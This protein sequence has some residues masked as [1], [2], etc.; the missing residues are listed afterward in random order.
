VQKV[1]SDL[2][3]EKFQFEKCLTN[4]GNYFIDKN[5]VLVDVRDNDLAK[6]LRTML[7]TEFCRFIQSDH[8]KCE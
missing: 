2:K 8:V 4:A 7:M 6:D 1:R 5:A 3:M